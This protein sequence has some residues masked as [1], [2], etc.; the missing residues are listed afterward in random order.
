VLATRRE[1]V[2]ASFLVTMVPCSARSAVVVAA[3]MPF[4]G[5]AAA[6]GAFALIVGLTIATGIAANALLPG[7]QSPLILELAPLR[8]PLARQVAG[9]AGARFRAFIRLAAPVMVVGSMLLGLAYETGLIWPV[10]AALDP[11]VVGWLGL[12]SVA[13]LALVF[14][15]LRKELALQLLLVLAVATLGAG[16]A[17][18]G[19]FMTPEQLFVYAIV[20][21]VSVPCIATLAAL[22]G[23]LGWR[24]AILMSGATLALAIGVGGILARLLGVV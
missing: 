23:E 15:F 14:A 19:D 22:A 21:S 8:R 2:L 17:S 3:V 16:A 11:V 13:G 10:S 24:T 7:R 4:A 1:R 20:T 5:A 12:P 9:K 18:L 6:A